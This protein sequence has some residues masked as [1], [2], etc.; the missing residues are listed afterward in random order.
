MA[1]TLTSGREFA[2][3]VERDVGDE[4][5]AC[6]IR[7]E[8]VACRLRNGDLSD[9]GAFASIGAAMREAARLL[10]HLP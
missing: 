2:V 10:D 4:R 9:V 1:E 8:S 6:A 5:L 3:W 7:F